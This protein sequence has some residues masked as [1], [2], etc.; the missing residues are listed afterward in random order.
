MDEATIVILITVA[1][2]STPIIILNVFYA[3]KRKFR[4]PLDY[5]AMREYAISQNHATR[6]SGK[7]T[8]IPKV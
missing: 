4:K 6:D 5:T 3:L 2:V 8:D 1:G 7:L